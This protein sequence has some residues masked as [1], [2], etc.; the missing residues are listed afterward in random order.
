MTDFLSKDDVSRPITLSEMHRLLDRMISMFSPPAPRVLLVED[1]PTDAVLAMRELDKFHVDL[2]AVS[3]AVAAKE[4]MK[5]KPF[6]Y[7]LLDLVLPGLSGIELIKET[8]PESAGENTHWIILTG[9]PDSQLV[10]EALKLGRLCIKKPLTE[11]VLKTFFRLKPIT[12]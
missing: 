12:K 8:L 2:T 5:A 6:D 11:A 9:M 3:N 7:V 4:A 1:D 10:S